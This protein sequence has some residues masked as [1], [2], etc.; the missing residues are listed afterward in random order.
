MLKEAL[1]VEM[2]VTVR[3]EPGSVLKSMDRSYIIL[4]LNKQ[5]KKLNLEEYSSTILEKLMDRLLHIPECLAIF[6]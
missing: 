2:N 1:I 4:V 5:H 3:H 6:E